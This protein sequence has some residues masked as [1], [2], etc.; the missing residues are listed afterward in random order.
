MRR[1]AIREAQ[2]EAGVPDGAVRA[3]LESVLDVGVWTY[4]TLVADVVEPFTPVISDP[5]SLELA[6]VP[7][8]DVAKLP[9]HPGFA[10]SWPL[11]RSLLPRHPVVVVDVANVVGS[12]PDG[13]WRDRAGAAS[14]LLD[15][16]SRRASRGVAADALWLEGDVWFPRW[17]AVVEG[18]ARAV[19]TEVAGVEVVAAPGEGDDAIVS[20]AA[21]FRDR[22][23]DVIVVT[24][25]RGLSERIVEVGGRVRG[26][27]WLRDLLNVD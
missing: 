8:D 6:W 12:V 11:L 23:H 24:S 22:G 21:E 5:E 26:V 2:E 18:Q 15:R 14:R 10:A 3:R 17:T 20:V 4:T 27:R 13:W 9:L 1:P 16:V 25:D 19:S 7:I